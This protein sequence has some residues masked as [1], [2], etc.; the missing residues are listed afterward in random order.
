[1]A[2]IKPTAAPAAKATSVQPKNQ[3]TLF[4]GLPR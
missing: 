4:H 1:M 3:A 2:D